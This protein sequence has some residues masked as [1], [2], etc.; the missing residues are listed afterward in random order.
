MNHGSTLI[1]PLFTLNCLVPLQ[2]EQKATLNNLPTTKQ[3]LRNKIAGNIKIHL[4]HFSK[5][6]PVLF[7]KAA[8]FS[9]RAFDFFSDVSRSVLTSA[10]EFSGVL[11]GELPS[12]FI[13]SGGR[14]F[15]AL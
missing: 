13:T 8:A 1:K 12:L 7:F 3:L 4:F 10:F 15:L 11:S 5:D 2:K 14:F 6:C 9:T